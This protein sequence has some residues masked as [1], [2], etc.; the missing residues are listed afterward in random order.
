MQV[1]AFGFF[2]GFNVTA[3]LQDERGNVMNLVV[4]AEVEI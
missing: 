4:I 1:P 3:N 2:V